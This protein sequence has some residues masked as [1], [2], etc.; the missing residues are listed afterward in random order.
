[1]LALF[2]FLCLA[3]L[4][5]FAD[6]KMFYYFQAVVL[7]IV[8]YIYILLL[9]FVHLLCN[10][11]VL[12]IF[13]SFLAARQEQ[14]ELAEHV[15]NNMTLFFLWVFKDQPHSIQSWIKWIIWR[16]SFRWTFPL[17][18]SLHV[19]YIYIHLEFVHKMSTLSFTWLVKR[20]PVFWIYCQMVRRCSVF[21]Q[22]RIFKKGEKLPPGPKLFD[23]KIVQ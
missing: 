17:N 9:K 4:S 6:L 20:R 11:N 8:L 14:L 3:V 7:L 16:A 13:F 2:V 21:L 22:G 23:Y 1:M 19:P 15:L 5:F 10:L 18:F 12:L